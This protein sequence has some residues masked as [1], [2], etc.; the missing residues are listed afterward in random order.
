MWLKP[1]VTAYSSSQQIAT[2]LIEK[3]GTG[4]MGAVYVGQRNI[5]GIKQKVAI[6]LLQ[7]H[8]T[9][10][11]HIERFNRE[12]R[13]L[14]QL[15]HPNIAQFVDS[16]YLED[17]NPYVVMEYTP[18]LPITQYCNLH[19]KSI[20]DRLQYF[21][22][23]CDALGYAHRNLI[24]H[25]DL[26]PSNILVTDEDAL[27]LIDFGIAK[28]ISNED[29]TATG[30]HLLTPAYASPEQFSGHAVNVTSDVYSSGVVLYELL[31]GLRPFDE[32][33]KALE[34][35]K[36]LAPSDKI[37]KLAQSTD[38]QISN[39]GL[40][41]ERLTHTLKNDLDKIILKSIQFDPSL[42]YQSITRICCGYS[43]VLE[44]RTCFSPRTQYC[45]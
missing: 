28:D 18:G 11:A 22:Y 41:V 8:K 24:I 40:S 5:E 21:L 45:V 42:R 4:G 3:I 43:K 30:H 31:T 35:Y 29:K 37:H 44:Q 17:G 25:R 15:N 38:H 10:A 20:Q 2:F 27:K 36:P 23:L 16:D 14:S 32:Q 1:L 19:E 13:I 9:D 7:L 39:T 34:A 6:K 12:C 26:K 33:H